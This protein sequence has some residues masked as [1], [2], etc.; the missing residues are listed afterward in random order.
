MWT[1]AALSLA[2]AVT[3][4]FPR[5]RERDGVLAA[6]AVGVIAAVWV[7]KGV[8]LVVAGF[9]PTPLGEIVPYA[10]TLPEVA[11]TAGVYSAGFL[12]LTLLCRIIVSVRTGP[13]RGWE[14]SRTAA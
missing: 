4:L 10:P 8:G 7:E 6:V 1:G 3:L 11:V 14:E 13:G 2:C 9:V 12:L 5:L